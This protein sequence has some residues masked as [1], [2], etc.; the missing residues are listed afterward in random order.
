[1]F[2]G[3][4]VPLRDSRVAYYT[5]IINNRHRHRHRM[6]ARHYHAKPS[7]GTTQKIGPYL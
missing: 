5:T 4:Y 3:K 6:K 2:G 1:M 7:D